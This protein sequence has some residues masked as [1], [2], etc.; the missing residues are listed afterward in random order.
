MILAASAECFLVLSSRRNQCAGQKNRPKSWSLLGSVYPSETQSIA[1]LAL[2][3]RPSPY[4]GT[5]EW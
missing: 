1:N 4:D 5:D 3:A 2:S